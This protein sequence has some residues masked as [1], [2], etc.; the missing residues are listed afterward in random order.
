MDRG[1][2]KLAI[3]PVDTRPFGLSFAD[4]AIKWWRW[5]FSIPKD[6]N[7]ATDSKGT[8]CDVQQKGPVWFLT[9]VTTSSSVVRKCIIPVR[10]AL[11]FP[12]INSE[13]ST[14]ENQDAKDSELLDYVVD[15]IDKVSSLELSVDRKRIDDLKKYRVLTPP[16][17]IKICNN[18]VLELTPGNARMVSDGFWIFLRPLPL[19][20]HMIHFR[21]VD[22]NLILD[23]T[24][25]IEIRDI[26][27]PYDV[28]LQNSK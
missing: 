22:P 23:V 16:F 25:M 8:N 5:L 2:Q 11:F 14:I 20:Q 27:N 21:G 10:R 26:N 7:P 19:G 15:D 1:T 9:G 13:Q 4:W 12:I 17:Q 18:N 28:A 3:Y 24:Y 6:K